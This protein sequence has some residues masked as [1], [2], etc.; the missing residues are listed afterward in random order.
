MSAKWPLVK[1]RNLLKRTER[2]EERDVLME[3][4]F[5]GTYSY[6]RGIF[7]GERKHGST[8]A[9]PKV[10]RIKTG[11][12]V[13]CKIMAWEGAFGLVP[14]KAN[15]CV[16]SGAFVTYEIDRDKL[17]PSFLAYYF[18]VPAHWKAIG[19]QSTGTNVRRQS[20][21]PSQFEAATIPLPPL[22][23]QRRLVARIEAVAALVAEA[24]ALRK[25]AVD[26]AEGLM[27]AI[28]KK[29]FRLPVQGEHVV[30]G[31][32]I[33][34]IEN[35]WSPAC[36]SRPA[37]TN[38][39]GVLKLGAVSFGTFNPN[40]NKALPP[41]LGPKLN[42]EIREG[43]FLMSRANTAELVGAC[44][45]VPN[46]RPMLML[47][48]KIFRIAL[49]ERS[50]V[51]V[52]WVDHALK[53]PLLRE[54]I[55]RVATGTSPTM[56]NISKE[57]I[58]GL[59]LPQH[60]PSTQIRTVRELD[61]L[62][63]QVDALKALQAET[64]AELDG[65]MS[66]VL[67]EAFN[68]RLTAQAV[69]QP[70]SV[71]LDLPMAAEPAAPYGTPRTLGWIDQVTFNAWM[72]HVANKDKYFGRTKAEKVEHMIECVVGH[73]HGRRAIRDAAGPV[74]HD[75]RLEV[76]NDMIERGWAGVEPI[77]LKNGHTMYLY[78]AVPRTVEVVRHV[79][80]LL[81][82][83]LAEAERIICIM[84]PLNTRQCEVRATLYSA[85]NDL[86]R[87]K[88]PHTDDDI[89]HDVLHNWHMRKQ[90]IPVVE[91]PAGLKWL[92]DNGL[93]PTGRAKPVRAK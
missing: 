67:N 51:H 48:D 1:L 35:G 44:A 78:H 68:G 75:R 36:E 81:G 83:G 79:Q 11:D 37:G 58:L 89:V 9:L 88:K 59:R 69:D 26:E 71:L 66:S 34:S 73:D 14:E 86:I 8:F 18:K 56:K 3:Y 17:D 72:V 16:L 38:E 30:L 60:D 82:D 90:D 57:K 47:C 24:Q 6:A 46:V 10:Q 39:W 27:T 13:Y 49:K 74:D 22:E 63:A 5:A 23:V 4:P 62:Q 50:P 33:R 77:D 21:H 31:E 92:R 2:W 61:A 28:R 76:E 55:S 84:R 43:D 15:D 7:V 93:V 91:W 65:M 85:W 80:E 32:L 53:S 29:L 19:S 12:F 52:R 20:L 70:K 64:Q 25:E 45:I 41:S 40:E 42:Y 87:A 54:Q